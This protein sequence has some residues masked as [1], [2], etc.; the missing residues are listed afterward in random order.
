MSSSYPV[1]CAAIALLVCLTFHG[2]AIRAE[3]DLWRTDFEAAK[4]QSQTEKKVLL[5]YY[6]ASDRVPPC[7]T[8]KREV[9]DSEAFEAEA[10]R[11]FVLVE[12]DFPGKKVLPAAVKKQNDELSRRYGV[13]QV[14]IVLLIAPD[15]AVIT[16]TGYRTGGGEKYVAHLRELTDAYARSIVLQGELPKSRGLERAKLLDEM[17]RCHDTLSHDKEIAL[18]LSR[19]IL[20]LD[21]RNQTGLNGNHVF[22]IAMDDADKLLKQRKIQES[23]AAYDRILALPGITALQKQ[24]AYMDQVGCYF[25]MR[26]FRGV[27]AGLEQARAA[28]PRSDRVES[29]YGRYEKSAPFAAAQKIIAEVNVSLGK[30]TGLERAV[31]LDRLFEAQRILKRALPDIT[32]TRSFEAWSREI[33]ALDAEN[34]A[35]LKAKHANSP[36]I[37]LTSMDL[38]A[39]NFTPA[40]GA[41]I[42][43]ANRLAQ[44]VVALYKQNRFRE[45]LPLAEECLAIRRKVL[46]NDNAGTAQAVNNVGAQLLGLTRYAEAIPYY[47]ESLA[48]RRRAF[49]N[50][51]LETVDSL[52]SFG[53]LFKAMGDYGK[54]RPYYEEALEI[55]TQVLG[56]RHPDTA[57]ALNHLGV[58]LRS[59]GEYETAR[60]YFERALAIYLEVYGEKHQSSAN[61]LG[62]LGSVSQSLGEEAT[63]RR[64]FERSLA[65]RKEVL[66]EK[67]LDAAHALDGIGG[68]LTSLGD[69]AAARPYFVQALAIKKEYYGDKHPDT[70]IALNAMGKSFVAMGE[71]QNAR[72]CHEQSLAIFKALT[73]DK[74]PEMAVSLNNLAAVLKVQEGQAAAL[75]YQ[76]QSLAICKESLGARHPS[77]AQAH[78]S[79]GWACRALGKYEAARTHLTQAVAIEREVLGPTHPSTAD[80]L[81][82]LGTILFDLGEV[83]QAI[84]YLAEGIGIRQVVQ[85]GVFAVASETESLKLVAKFRWPLDVL[86]TASKN[87]EQANNELYAHIWP[88]RAAVF[89]LAAD[90]C[91][92]LAH[93]LAPEVEP[94]YRTWLETRRELSRL[95]LAPMNAADPERLA[96]RRE[97]LRQTTIRKEELERRLAAFVPEIAQGQAQRRRP[98]TDL[99]HALPADAVF[100]DLLR[101]EHCIHDPNIEASKANY[102]I[103]SYVAFVVTRDGPLQRID[104]GPAAPIDAQA[105]AWREAMLSGKSA[106][107]VE[108]L[109]RL[110]WQPLHAAL[111]ADVNTVYLVPDGPLTSLP[112]AALPGSKPGT[113]LLEETALAIVPNGRVLLDHLERPSTPTSEGALLAVGGVQY[114]V[115][116]IDASTSMQIAKLRAAATDEKQTLHWPELPGTAN[117]VTGIERFVGER[118]VV[119]LTGNAAG[120]AR[121]ISELPKA[122]WAVFATHGFFADPA[123]RSAMQIDESSFR[124]RL[125]D[126]ASNLTGRNPLLLSGLVFAGANLPRPLDDSGVPQGDGGILTA[127]AIAGLPLSKLELAVLSACETGL[128]EV[129][130]GEGVFGLQRAFH[131]AGCRNVVASLWKVDDEATSALMRLFYENLWRKN[132][133]PL[134]ALRNAQLTILRNPTEIRA[135]AGRAP[136]AAKPLPD[137]G[138]ISAASVA[139]ARAD[140]RR[141]AAFQ[142]SGSGK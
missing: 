89:Q 72:L 76:E 9:F 67:S 14:P 70:A 28:A 123:M 87:T 97:L 134:E 4:I 108:E 24:A 66:G 113:V 27:I 83:D 125:P 35:G 53:S 22:R 73:G 81:I 49:G 126:V 52:T 109:R 62:N 11:R 65:I 48:G 16:K 58:L 30:A 93:S 90:R 129:A 20:D 51:T 26:D 138:R 45:A 98:H 127:E 12:V 29:I 33:V 114:G 105:K 101:F 43:E 34:K 106:T 64:Y 136:G 141:W 5:L 80:S 122:R 107:A 111:P 85:D 118:S 110:V 44:E 6:T 25:E 100:I 119:K 78:S 69:H 75:P 91:Q 8:M 82:S 130:G 50:R 7:M 39:K 13:T 96:V 36:P 1:R 137:G 63:A 71:F 54:S 68:V 32:P 95:T 41:Q 61:A 128:G 139:P 79:V 131:V 115:A 132:Q 102:S 116:P 88:G 94:L 37:E 135:Y 92:T 140:V 55:S 60:S 3:G 40:E 15:G 142:L 47:E 18:A 74:H 56:P 59:M 2:G 103:P 121:V 46:G 31:L 112:W 23:L 10:R 19:E 86:I 120:T 133:R 21:P 38:T 104:L 77:T 57:V 84:K 99:A 42:Q 124:D 117:E 17:V